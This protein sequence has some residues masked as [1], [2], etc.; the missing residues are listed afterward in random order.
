MVGKSVRMWGTKMSGRT[1]KAREHGDLAAG[2]DG[3]AAVHEAA[4]ERIRR[5]WSRRWRRCR[6]DDERVLACVEVEAVVVVEELGEIEEVEPPDA[7][8]EAFADGEGVGAAVAQQDW[9]RME[10]PCGDGGEVALG[11]WVEPRR[12][13]L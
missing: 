3:V 5:R 11:G 7:V 9:S 10:P 2:V 6:G 13:L 1:Q 4:G 12:S 8:G